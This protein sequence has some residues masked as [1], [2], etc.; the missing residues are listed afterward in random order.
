MTCSQI[1][2]VYLGFKTP[3]GTYLPWAKGGDNY[4]H[5]MLGGRHKAG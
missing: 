2:T 3:S 1:C 4:L 5:M